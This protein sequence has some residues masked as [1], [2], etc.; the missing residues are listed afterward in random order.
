[1][2]KGRFNNSGGQ[3]KIQVRKNHS[4]RVFLQCLVNDNKTDSKK[5]SVQI[6]L[7]NAWISDENTL[8]GR[9]SLN[10]EKNELSAELTNLTTGVSARSKTAELNNNFGAVAPHAGECGSPESFGGNVT[11]GNKPLCPNQ[12]LDTNDAFRGKVQSI[13]IQRF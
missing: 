2:Q 1:M 4:G 3:W 5:E 12:Q 10:R 11:I 7:K 6:R 9:C 8:E 13:L